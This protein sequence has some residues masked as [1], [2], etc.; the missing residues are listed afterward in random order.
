M[1]SFDDILNNRLKMGNYQFK[2]ISVI[3]LIEFIDGIE[4]IYLSILLSILKN[5]W[6]LNQSTLSMLGS[7]YFLGIVIGNI[8]CALIADAIGRRRTIIISCL[9]QISIIF[10][11]S[12]VQNANELAVLRL[13][14]GIIFGITIPLSYVFSSEIVVN[15]YRG[16]VG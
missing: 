8:I 2:I 9:F 5:E 7:S 4:Y 12:H 11:T 3:G 6:D 13:L 15:Q 1:K 14:Y 10:L 16:R